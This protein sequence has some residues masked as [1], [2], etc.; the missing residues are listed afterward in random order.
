M[1][2]IIRYSLII[3][4]FFC[5]VMSFVFLIENY[6]DIH[7]VEPWLGKYYSKSGE[8]VI[9]YRNG[10]LKSSSR[11][12]LI[13]KYMIENTEFNGTH[14]FRIT[15]YIKDPIT[16]MEQLFM[17]R[18]EKIS[19]KFDKLTYFDDIY[20]RTLSSTGGNSRAN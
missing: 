7:K 18:E 12:G 17:A 20:T 4:V 9:L 6:I 1:K 14:K 13:S 19:V 2:K 16:N 11:S 5:L 8:W 10:T 3:S 15:E